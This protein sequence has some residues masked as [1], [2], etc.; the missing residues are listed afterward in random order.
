[1]RLATISLANY[2]DGGSAQDALVD[3]KH[4]VRRD[5]LRKAILAYLR[6]T[7]LAADTADGMIAMWIPTIGFEEAPE[8]IE[9]VLQQL[10]N[11]G[12]LAARPLSDGK[13]VYSLADPSGE[14]KN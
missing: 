6:S 12:I 10:V 9:S 3:S 11:D 2:C 13:S 14:S 4:D 1:M 7:P 8:L 5:K